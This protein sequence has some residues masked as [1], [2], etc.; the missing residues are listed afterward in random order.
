MFGVVIGRQDSDIDL[1][2]WGIETHEQATARVKQIYEDI[3]KN[4]PSGEKPLVIRTARTVTI[5]QK[6][7]EYI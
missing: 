5:L 1:F 2:V 7:G 6:Y 3:C 4:L